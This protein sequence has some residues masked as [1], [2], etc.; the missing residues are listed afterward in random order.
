MTG[1]RADESGPQQAKYPAIKKTDGPCQKYVQ[2][3]IIIKLILYVIFLGR[4][5]MRAVMISL[6]LLLVPGLVRA[7]VVFDQTSSS[8]N[9]AYA[10]STTGNTIGQSFSNIGQPAPVSSVM[11]A[12]KRN[13]ATAFAGNLQ[14]SIFLANVTS[15]PTTYFQTGSALA[16]SALLD[17]STVGTSAVN[18]TFTGFGATNLSASTV[19]MAVLQLSGITNFNSSTLDVMGYN[20]IPAGTYANYNLAFD[21]A[22]VTNQQMY[23]TI[24]VVP[25]PG[26]LLLGAIAAACGGGGLWWRR[27]RKQPVVA[28]DAE[29]NPAL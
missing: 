4:I 27:K 6:A 20:G 22:A 23:G 17:A 13:G 16:T 5:S 7:D 10:M 26:T 19:Y 14:V 11:F 2:T 9:L 24:T 28:Q 8:V 29:V 3:A 15:G 1:L 25:E 21:G 12:L 18:Y